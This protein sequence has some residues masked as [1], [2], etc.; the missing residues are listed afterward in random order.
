MQ[1][2]T[3][4][5]PDPCFANPAR[6]ASSTITQEHSGGGVASDVVDGR[7]EFGI[8]LLPGERALF[9][10]DRSHSAGVAP[11]SAPAVVAE[12]NLW[13][14][15]VESW[16]PGPMELITEDRGMG[17]VATEARPTTDVT[18][19][20]VGLTPLLPWSWRPAVG[21]SVSGVG[22]YRAVV[23]V[24]AVRAGRYVLDLGST[25]SGIGAVY[26]N[27]GPARGFDTTC[28]SVDITQDLRGGVND[29][30]VRVASSL[31]N[32]LRAVGYY[33]DLEDVH[34]LIVGDKPEPHTTVVS[35]SGLLCPVRLRHSSALWACRLPAAA[36]H[37]THLQVPE[38]AVTD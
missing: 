35:H 2:A 16:G 28:P 37:R 11:E 33:D 24:D 14:L 18:S 38:G 25:A 17:Y 10:L 4:A 1:I 30:R 15:E 13:E 20:A 6:L 19:L 9:V 5:I 26:V 3:T 21:D 27:D 23:N 32:V 31:N 36:N 34:S 12:L 22:E 8:T 29:V 7:T